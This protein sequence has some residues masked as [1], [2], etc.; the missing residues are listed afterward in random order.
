M[1]IYKTV[2]VPA[3]TEERLE[4]TTCDLCGN[5]IPAKSSYDVSEITIRHKTGSNY[6]EGGSGVDYEVD[7]C[8]ACWKDKLLP[9]LAT[10]GAKLAEREWYF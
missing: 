4:K 6:P 10:F 8:L 2:E 7:M 3:K 5:E 9:W 1:R